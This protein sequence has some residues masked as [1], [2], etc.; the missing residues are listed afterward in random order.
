MTTKTLPGTTPVSDATVEAFASFFRGRTDAW[1]SVT[2]MCNKEQVTLEHYRRHL[3]GKESLGV[4][5]LLDD[6]KCF[7]AAADLDEKDQ[8]KILAIKE[9]F[10]EVGVHAYPCFSKGKGFHCYVFADK[11]PFDAHEIRRL[12]VSVLTKLG[13]ECEIFPKQDK[14]DEKIPLGNYINLPLFGMNTRL[15]FTKA[16]VIVPADQVLPLFQRNT[17]ETIAIARKTIPDPAAIKPTAPQATKVKGRPKK[18]KQPVCIEQLLKGVPAGS[19]DVAAFAL[20]RWYLEQNFLPEEVVPYLEIWDAKNTPPIGDPRV[21][22]T[23]VQSAAKGYGF[24]CNSITSEPLLS[25]MCLGAAQCVWLKEKTEERKKNGLIREISFHSTDTHLFEQIY[26]GKEKTQFISYELSTGATQVVDNI[27]YPSY[28]VVPV[29][30]A[31]LT[32]SVIK[33]PTGIAPATSLSILELEDELIKDIIQLVYDYVELPLERDYWIVAHY[34][35]LTWVYDKL[36]TISYLRFRGDTG[37]LIAGTKV[38]LGDGSFKNIE[39]LGENHLQDINVPLRI[40]GQ[41]G[42]KTSPATK[43]HIYHDQPVLKIRTETGKEITGT[44]NHPLLVKIEGTPA[45][46]EWKELGKLRVGDKLRT[47]T[48]I[49]GRKGKGN[50][51]RAGILGYMLG[52]GSI[53]KKRNSFVLLISEKEKAL[54][55]ELT[56][57]IETDLKVSPNHQIRHHKD[58][59]QDIHILEVNGKVIEPYHVMRTKS[60]P[61]EIMQ[62]TNQEVASFLSWLFT[63]EGC[64]Y[65]KGRGRRAIVCTQKDTQILRDVQLLLLRFGIHSRITGKDLYIRRGE[66]I[67]KFRDNIGFKFEGKNERLANLV[68]YV[69]SSERSLSTRGRTPWEAIVSIEPAGIADVYDVEVP[70]VRRFIANGFVSH[71]TGKSRAL[72]VIGGICYKPLMM[73]GAVTPA[74]IYREIRRFRGTVI[75]EEADFSDS[76]EKGEV[77]TILNCGMERGRAVLRCSPDDPNIIECLPVYGPKLFAT[78]GPFQDKALEARCN[79]IIMKEAKRK[80][81]TL[82]NNAYEVRAADLRKKLLL[83]RFLK[84]PLVDPEI[85]EIELG[86]VEQ[87]LKQMA[88]PLAIVFHDR[89]GFVD[90]LR[91]SVKVAQKNIRTDRADSE[92][93]AVLETFLTI[94]LT[95]GKDWVSSREIGVRMAAEGYFSKYQKEGDTTA[96]SKKVS[97]AVSAR[98]RNLGFSVEEQPKMHNSKRDRHII[99]DQELVN[100]LAI[101]YLPDAMD[102]FEELLTEKPEKIDLDI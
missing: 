1:G 100:Q 72:T 24:G 89:P 53:R 92:D 59:R 44:Y 17:N 19:R 3:E 34:V 91:E 43:F 36:N 2:G 7:F 84:M 77:V 78:R 49:P 73:S 14:L 58:G 85:E 47:V 86:P 45:A 82:I 11:M 46:S 12:F 68:E 29:H 52:D 28:T 95:D 13:I 102:E 37:C 39:R 97:V 38:V 80:V 6:G 9:G 71:N 32:E 51:V 41:K 22:L 4:Y 64:V 87:R 54:V 48:Q 61:D 62:G 23:K 69:S 101:K 63:A 98:I 42:A 31:E 99:W 93:A 79:T 40:A 5:M 88:L 96:F 10:A 16:K 57:M 21:L 8:D 60:I 33:F 18:I 26:D 30:G 65:S 66:S 70:E 35:L 27:E 74:P 55:P 67:V 25:H 90:Q 56:S 20:S 81:P 75:L 15:F 50:P 94:A 76:S 83:W